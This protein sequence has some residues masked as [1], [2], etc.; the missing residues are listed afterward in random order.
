MST[1]KVKCPNCA[2]EFNVEEALS[3]DIETQIRNKY[4]DTLKKDREVLEKQRE[5]LTKQG[6][7]QN[8]IIS[9][10]LAEEKEKL[11]AEIKKEAGKELEGKLKLL[12]TE[13]LEK[14]EKLKELQLKEI[15]FLKEKNKLQGAMDELKIKLEREMLEKQ[16]EVIANARKQEREQTELVVKELQK[17]LED[18]K[19]LTE[20]MKRKQE[21]GS[22]QLQGEVQE[23][24]LEEMLQAAFPFDIIDEVA[25]GVRGADAVQTV[26]NNVG[27]VSGKII[28][29]SK[30]TKNFDNKWIEKLKT[31]LRS[32]N[33]DI[34]VIVTETMPRDMDHFGQKDGVWICTFAEARSLAFVLRESL[35]RISTVMAS[36]ENKGDKMVMLYNYLTGNEFA[37]Q[38]TAII[39]GFESMKSSISKER[40]SM[41]KLWKEREKQLEKVLINAVG[42]YGS[43][44][45]IAGNSIP[46]IK[47]LEGENEITE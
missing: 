23:L 47:L 22:M 4:L 1:N 6:L 39:E 43:V 16:N 34:A 21:Q 46:D 31:D 18:Q 10:K 29:E 2:H 8:E 20:E 41:E 30:R 25:K 7:Q 5:E 24:F 17:Q 9:K 11:T 35:M 37:L 36:Q 12:E 15:E 28:Y 27:V 19:K 45:G 13:S 32:Q 38:L 3:K 42:F 40:M 26:R 44:K 33:A 14:G